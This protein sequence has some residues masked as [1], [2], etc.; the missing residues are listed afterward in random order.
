MYRDGSHLLDEHDRAVCAIQIAE[1]LIE[2]CVRAVATMDA[3]ESPERWSNA[4][5]LQDHAVEVWMQLDSARA[6]LAARGAN[7]IAYDELRARIT[8]VLAI[9]YRDGI[10]GLDADSLDDARRAVAEL[11]LAMPGADWSAIAARTRTLVQTPLF[12]RGQRLALVAIVLLLGAAVAGWAYAIIPEKRVDPRV[13]LRAELAE[14][15]VERRD[16]IAE[17]EAQ[18]GDTCDRATVHELMKL[19]VMDGRFADATT[20]GQGFERR[21]GDDPVVRKWANAPR[22]RR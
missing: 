13:V 22:P 8:P 19:W 21:C 11:K 15:V 20:F 1:E 12:Q 9:T 6:S 18:V 16:R 4:R 10:H 3:R 2:S 14:I 17:L 5:T 7:T